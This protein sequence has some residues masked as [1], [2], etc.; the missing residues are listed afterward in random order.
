LLAPLFELRRTE[1][2]RI[3]FFHTPFDLDRAF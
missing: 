3:F 1:L 2:S